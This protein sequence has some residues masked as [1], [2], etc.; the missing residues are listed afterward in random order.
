MVPLEWGSV[1][2]Y[3]CKKD[4]SHLLKLSPKLNNVGS[5]RNPIKV[6]LISKFTGECYDRTI[7]TK[8][9]PKSRSR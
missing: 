3:S 5:A 6:F 7:Q 4:I 1:L 9:K 8:S 2:I